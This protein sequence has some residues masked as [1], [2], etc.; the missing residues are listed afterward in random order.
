MCELFGLNSN[1]PVPPGELLCRFGAR[2]GDTADN[3]DGWGLAVLEDS[4]FCL[5]KEPMAAARSARF[6]Q[7]CGPIRRLSAAQTS[8]VS[9]ATSRPAGRARERESPPRRD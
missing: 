4:T 1:R 7:L 9:C 5:T 3:P 2:G 6:R 8:A